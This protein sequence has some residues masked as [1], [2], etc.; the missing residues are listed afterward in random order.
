[1]LGQGQSDGD[2]RFR[3]D[4]PRTASTRILG[5]L[6]LAAAPGYGLGSAWLNPDA[7][8]PTADIRLLPEQGVNPLRPLNFRYSGKPT[9]Q[10]GVEVERKWKRS[11]YCRPGTAKLVQIE[12]H[13]QDQK[14]NVEELNHG[15]RRRIS[16]L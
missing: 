16:N 5:I 3:I 10:I 14:T 7:E 8:Q 13:Q 4:A 1:M 15:S 2:G 9:P 6:A 11:D 12:L